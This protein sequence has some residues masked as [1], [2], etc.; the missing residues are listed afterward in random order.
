MSP[1]LYLLSIVGLDILGLF[2]NIRMLLGCLR[3]E[4]RYLTFWVI[5]QYVFQVTI[6]VAVTVDAWNKHVDEYC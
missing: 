3:K 5:C 1:L 4:N 2:F 6:L